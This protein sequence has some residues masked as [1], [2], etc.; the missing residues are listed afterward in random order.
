MERMTTSADP[1]FTLLETV[2]VVA[3]IAILSITA[4]FAA[5]TR[6]AGEGDRARFAATYD[7][8]RD[9]AILGR[10]PQALAIVP[11]GWQIL[12]PERA[13]SGA[14]VWA[15]SGNPQ[16]FIAEARFE[17][18]SGAIVPHDLSLAPE[19]DLIFLPDGQVTPFEVAFIGNGTLTRCRSTGFAGLVC[20]EP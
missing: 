12:L 10:S 17:G 15:R 11:E 6:R 9:A 2:V 19:P 16:K 7:R 13:E 3:V 14:T 20:E 18:E 1:G 4:T 8:L 5:T